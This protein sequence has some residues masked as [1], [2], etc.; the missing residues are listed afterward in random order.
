MMQ[1]VASS[2]TVT[3]VVGGASAS[4][5]GVDLRGWPHL[6]EY[7]VQPHERP[8]QVDLDPAWGAGDVLAVVLGTP[9]F[10]KTHANGAHLGELV[11]SLKA[12]VDRESQQLGKLLVVED[13]E[14]AAWGDL[15][16]RCW[17]E[18]MRVVALPA[19]DKDSTITEALSKNLSSNIEQMHT[20]ANVPADIL[21]GGVAVDIGQKAK[22]EPVQVGRGVC[23]AVHHHMGTCG[24]KG[25]TNT[26]VELIIA[27]G[28]PVRRLLVLD[29][30]CHG[31][32]RGGGGNSRR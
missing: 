14:A 13:L 7:L 2:E 25:L 24:V 11:D 12:L 31:H 26:L 15:A 17:V 16:H 10:H 5:Y 9:A 3:A 19:L 20:L 30:H 6:R 18:A 32:I 23:K 22:T 1:E 4:G 27:D 29:W 8:V 21:N 28:A